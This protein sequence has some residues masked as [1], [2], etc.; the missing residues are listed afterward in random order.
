MCLKLLAAIYR[1]QIY[2]SD[3][4][5]GSAWLCNKSMSVAYKGCAPLI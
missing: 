1:R 3:I 4:T 5:Y 2:T